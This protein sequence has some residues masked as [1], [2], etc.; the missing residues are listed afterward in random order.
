MSVVLFNMT[1]LMAYVEI[2]SNEIKIVNGLYSL[3][4]WKWVFI[5]I[6]RYIKLLFHKWVWKTQKQTNPL[7]LRW[8]P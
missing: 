8:K 1:F 3:L 2:L 4:L 6:E 5:G 7:L